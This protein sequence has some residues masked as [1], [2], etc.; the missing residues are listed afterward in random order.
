VVADGRAFL[1]RDHRT[2]D[3]ILLDAYRGPFVP[4]HL[5]TKEFFALVKSRLSPGG[6][7]LQNIEPTTMLFDSAT[8]TLHSVFPAVDFYDGVENVVAVGYDG[9]PHRQ[10]DLLARAA[11]A[12]QRYK[13][14]YDLRRLV[15][16]RRVLRRPVGKVMTDDFAPVETL[17]AIE[18]NNEKWKEQTEAPR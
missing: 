13:L 7:V 1:L 10:A 8:A 18:K 2:W 11:A 14:R 9:P 16:D 3:V 12:Q 15:A 5:L 4:F 6:V 17:R